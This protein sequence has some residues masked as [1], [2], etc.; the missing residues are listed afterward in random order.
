LVAVRAVRFSPRNAAH[1]D[2]VSVT[3]KKDLASSM[4][5]ASGNVNIHGPQ[6]KGGLL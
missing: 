5:R 6:T 4:L 3:N 2:G 1:L